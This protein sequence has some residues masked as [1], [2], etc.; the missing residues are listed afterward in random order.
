M[1][2]ILWAFLLIFGVSAAIL[3][4]MGAVPGMPGK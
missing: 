1:L 3:V 2:I 4:A